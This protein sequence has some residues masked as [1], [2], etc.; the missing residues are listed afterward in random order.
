MG[1]ERRSTYADP[2]IHTHTHTLSK[3]EKYHHESI[4]SFLHIY[5]AY[6]TEVFLEKKNEKKRLKKCSVQESN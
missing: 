5:F 1:G 6:R 4:D 3:T 2:Y